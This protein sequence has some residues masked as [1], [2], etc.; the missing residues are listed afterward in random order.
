[1]NLDIARAKPTHA[2]IGFAYTKAT[3]EQRQRG[4]ILQKIDVRQKMFE[5]KGVQFEFP[6]PDSSMSIGKYA[7]KCLANCLKE[8]D[9]LYANV[10]PVSGQMDLP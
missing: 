6:W 5:Q 3:D 10:G 7:E 8:K 4:A 2:D 9:L 1:M